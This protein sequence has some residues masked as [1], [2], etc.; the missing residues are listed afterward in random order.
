MIGAG[1]FSRR[2][3]ILV[4]FAQTVTAQQE[5][6]GVLD[7]AV[8]DGCGD[9]RIKEDV[10]PVGKRGVGGDHGRAF[11]AMACRDHLIKEIGG[12]LVEGQIAQLIANEQ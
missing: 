7:Q 5:D 11:V 9:G 2:I 4:G 1:L 6:L 8:G 10:T 3:R 12:L